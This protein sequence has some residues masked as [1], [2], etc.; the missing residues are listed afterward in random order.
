MDGHFRKAGRTVVLATHNNRLLPLTDEILMLDNGR[1]SR[2]GAYEQLRSMIPEDSRVQHTE[3]SET[4][5]SPTDKPIEMTSVSQMLQAVPKNDADASMI[6]RDGS[7]SVYVFYF[8]SAGWIVVITVG[9]C[10]ALYGFSE[11]FSSEFFSTLIRIILTNNSCVA[12][13]VVECQR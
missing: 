6:R 3:E 12:S 9:L 13:T 2:T 7:W 10:V 11:Q 8:Q 4:Q 5:R 1:L